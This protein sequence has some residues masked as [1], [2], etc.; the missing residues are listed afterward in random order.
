MTSRLGRWFITLPEDATLVTPDGRSFTNGR[1]LYYDSP[2]FGA[3][4]AQPQI[5]LRLVPAGLGVH[6]L[7]MLDTGAPWCIFEPSIANSIEDRLEELPGTSTLDTRLGRFEGKLCI[8][9]LTLLATE[10]ADLDVEA[11]IFLCP[12]WPGGNVV[13]YIGFLARISS[14]LEPGSNDFF[15][16]PLR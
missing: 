6:V 12:D 5:Y 1:A 9:T 13:G 2:T 4:A 7:V 8:G 14:G 16:G 3:P 15:F 10:G 11:T